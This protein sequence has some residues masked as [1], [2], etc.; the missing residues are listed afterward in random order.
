MLQAEVRHPAGDETR[1]VHVS[2]DDRRQHHGK[3]VHR[4]ARDRI[5]HSGQVEQ[6]LN[7]AFPHLP[8][9]PLVF[10]PDLLV[11]RVRRPL[12]ADAVQVLESDL[13]DAVSLIQVREELHPQLG[14][15][16]QIG[17]ARGTSRQLGK[18]RLRL[19]LLPGQEFALG[20]LQL[21]REDQFV[22]ALPCILRQQRTTGD[23]IGQRRGIGGRDLGAPAGDQVQLGQPLAF[24]QR[25]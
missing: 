9:Q 7:R 16:G 20:S 19:R 11:R 13:N 10:L 8:P 25:R 12:D 2:D 15:G 14:D 18:A 21:Q 6:R 17:K 5:V 3:Y 23:D 1:Q 24:L 22:P 4:P